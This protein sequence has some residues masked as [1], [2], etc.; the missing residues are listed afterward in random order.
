MTEG[1][2]PGL[3][4]QETSFFYNILLFGKVTEVIE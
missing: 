3:A 2:D 4:D 1:K